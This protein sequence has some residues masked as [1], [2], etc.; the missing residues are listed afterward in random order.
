MSHGEPSGSMTTSAAQRW[1]VSWT[2]DVLIYVVILNLF[3]EFSD[4]I[5]IE[6]FW[7]SLL[8][9]VVL[10]ILLDIV[11]W[12]EHR[13]SHLFDRSEGMVGGWLGFIATIVVL[14]AGKFSSCTGWR[15]SSARRYTSATWSR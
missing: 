1:F 14:I 15:R 5:T 4:A 8:T 11:L 3:K 2:T 6:S 10:K 13:T 9:A 12:F 7:I